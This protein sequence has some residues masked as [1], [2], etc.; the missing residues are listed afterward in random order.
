MF[1]PCSQLA[2]SKAALA[3]AGPG[4]A[5]LSKLRAAARAGGPLAAA[6]FYGRLGDLGSIAAQYD[7]AVTTACGALN[8]LVVAHT[9]GA[10]ACVEFLRAHGLGRAKFIILDKVAAGAG[11]RMDAPFEAPEGVP[12]LFDLVKVRDAAMR[13]AFY[14]A[15]RDTLV[16]ESIDQVRAASHVCVTDRTCDSPAA[17]LPCRPSASATLAAAPPTGSSR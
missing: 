1:A 9:E 7:T 6:G 4:D 15:L 14:F 16:A 17:S 10:Q 2:E 13:P 11:A 8:W 5:M 3:E 12:R